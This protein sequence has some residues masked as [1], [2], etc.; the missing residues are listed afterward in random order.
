MYRGLARYYLNKKEY[1]KASL[2]IEKINEPD[3]NELGILWRSMLQTGKTKEVKK[4][5]REHIR[6][7]QESCDAYF[8]LA[9]LEAQ[10]GN[11]KRAEI[12][13]VY[14]LDHGFNNTEEI[15]SYDAL[16]GIF[17][18]MTGKNLVEEA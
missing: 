2:F 13:L 12:L 14:A 8:L 17:E 10:N 11:F 9:V 1:V 6:K 5:L 18:N 7:N 16:H 15:Q 3:E 4:M